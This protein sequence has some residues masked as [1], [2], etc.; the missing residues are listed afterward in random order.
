MTDSTQTKMAKGAV[1]MV[2]FKL[3]E[4]GLG[5]ISTLIL[6]RLLAPGDFGVIAMALSF[7]AMAELMAAFSF[8]TAIIHNQ[9]ATA[10]HLNSAWTCSFLLGLFI[11]VLMVAMAHPVSVFYQKPEL[12]WV[13]VAL[14]FGPL[15]TGSQNIG[16]VAFRKELDFRKE[17]RFQVSRKL[18]SFC[19]V[20]PLAFML[21]SHWALVIGILVSSLAGTGMSYLMH[22]YR[23]RL[24]FSKAMELFKFSRW[25]LINN[26]AGFFKERS[27]D[28]FIG[29]MTG[30]TSLGTYNLAY[31][32]SSLPTTEIGAPINRALL[33]GFAK[34]KD[35]A[36]IASAYSNAVGL[37]SLLALP[38]AACI[39]ALAPFL[40]PVILGEKW[41]AAVP[42]MQLLAFNG[43]LL[44]FHGSVCA[45]LIGRGFPARVMVAN[46][47][48]AL[49]LIG[50]LS[51]VFTL[52]PEWGV[53][54]AAYAALATS[55][56]A[57]PVYL[58]QL[59]RCL[60]LRPILFVRAIF[61]PF[62]GSLCVIGL[63]PWMLPTF[64]A[65]KPF[66][67][68]L[69]WLAGGGVVAVSLYALTVL[70][71][72]TLVGRP[73]GAERIFLSQ[74]RAIVVER[75]GRRPASA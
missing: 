25:L 58:H 9:L 73:H 43:A 13:V 56:A 50:L 11:T 61:R 69:A 63:I 19:I 49:V 20:V 36:E 62:M 72:W 42:L 38:S 64:V 6:A 29:R 3:V 68:N 60:D 8:D 44:L 66:W 47:T 14:S 10:E 65:G 22:P 21:R 71:L 17:F 2:M 5:L 45:L 30:A 54:G 1:W 74:A 53:L 39:F 75:S 18:I 40:V 51:A 46:V 57:T 12:F 28:F 23:P 37:L 24:G 32:I 52:R 7:I 59:K 34:M 48:Y 16:V 70:M 35:E 27:A 55:L 26:F 4:R 31:E 41:L 67:F 33:P 15:I